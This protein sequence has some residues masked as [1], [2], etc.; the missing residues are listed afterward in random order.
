[1]LPPWDSL[2]AFSCQRSARNI[3]LLNGDADSRLLFF[4]LEESNNS[5][6]H[7]RKNKMLEFT[8]LLTSQRGFPMTRYTQIVIAVILVCCLAGCGDS[9][10]PTK[11]GENAPAG[12]VESTFFSGATLIPGDGS[13]VI[14]DAAILVE[15]GKFKAIG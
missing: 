7:L 2:S 6:L 10:A 8:T 3:L 15:N 11:G 13:P 14:E 12:A 1:G 5:V 9:S 4:K